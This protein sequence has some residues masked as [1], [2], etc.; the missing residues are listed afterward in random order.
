MAFDYKRFTTDPVDTLPDTAATLY[1][2]TDTT[3][4]LT[5]ISIH[6]SNTTSEDVKIWLV[7]VGDTQTDL[8]QV[9]SVSL[10]PGET[11]T[12]ELKLP[13]Y[14]LDTG[15]MIWGLADTASKVTVAL[16]GGAE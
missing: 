12:R 1:T 11:F 3:A 8:N 13:G 6:N 10:S 15:D 4:Y 2:V 5:T 14:I 9:V 16:T 7:N